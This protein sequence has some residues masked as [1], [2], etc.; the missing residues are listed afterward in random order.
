MPSDGKREVIMGINQSGGNTTIQVCIGKLFAIENIVTY[1][2]YQ[3]KQVSACLVGASQGLD[4][5]RVK[6]E[7]LALMDQMTT[8]ELRRMSGIEHERRTV[9]DT[10]RILEEQKRQI[11]EL[12]K[13]RIAEQEGRAAQ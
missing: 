9:M 1:L 3:L 7:D 4:T 12:A 13:A 8:D 10:W 5:E 11:V 2:G 6:A